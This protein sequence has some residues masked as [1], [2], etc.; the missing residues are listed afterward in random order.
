MTTQP[1]PGDNLAAWAAAEGCALIDLR[2][3]DLLGRWLGTTLRADRAEDSARGVFVASSTVAGWARL[4]NSDLLLLPDASTRLRDPLARLPTMIV[5]ASAGDVATLAPSPLDARSTL[6]RALALLG[7]RGIADELRV[8]VELEFHLFDDVR[9]HMS[10]T[11]CFFRIGERDALDNAAR[12]LAGGNPGHRVGYP[13]QHLAGAPLDGAVAWRGALLDLAARA[14]LD[15]LK[16]QHEAG[17]SQHEIVLRHAPAL[18]AADR[19]QIAKYLTLNAASADGR[20]ATFMPKPLAYQPG[21]GLHLNLSLWR[22]GRPLFA[23]A[24]GEGLARSFIAGVFAHAPAL[25]AICNPGTNSFRRLASLYHPNARLVWGVAN[26]A[27]AIRVPRALD[28][29]SLRLEMRFPDASSN[30]YLAIA[31]LA[32][33]GVDGIVRTLDPGPPDESDPRRS[34]RWDVRRR[35]TPAFALDLAE[36]IVALDSDRAFLAADGVFAES[37]IDALLD[38]LNRQLRVNRAL[39]HPNEY[40]LYYSV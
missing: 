10:P 18:V 8:G 14:G 30:P 35:S 39:P 12:P 27:A 5:M 38:E 23:G 32:M 24:E 13:S 6:A 1:S 28:G 29:R 22:D 40:Y 11:E 34:E 37:L 7:A 25:N 33:A 16:H 3:T 15:P 31:A 2:F 17:P 36:A 21:S 26:R 4:E 9:F 19:I 20:T